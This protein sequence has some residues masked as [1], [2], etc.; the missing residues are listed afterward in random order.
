V[1]LCIQLK[2]EEVSMLARHDILDPGRKFDPG[3]GFPWEQ[4][5]QDTGF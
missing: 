5:K 2:K 3:K 4:F 1:E